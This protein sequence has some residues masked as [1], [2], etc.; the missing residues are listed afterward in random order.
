[1]LQIVANALLKEFPSKNV[2][3]VGG[4]EFVVV[5]EGVNAERC[6]V[7]MGRV[8]KEVES[9]GYHIA[10]GIAHQKDGASANRLAQEADMRMLENK[11]EYYE[12]LELR[13]PRE[14]E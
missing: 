3:R 6:A 11:R 10:Y 8:A 12:E 4:D 2:F 7:K 14:C 5:I 13:A 9:H 1:M